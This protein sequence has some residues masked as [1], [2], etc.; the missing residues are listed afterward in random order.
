MNGFGQFFWQKS[1][2]YYKGQYEN[3]L[4]HGKGV[5]QWG[6]SRRY[7][8]DWAYG[9]RHGYGELI[10]IDPIDE[11]ENVNAQEEKKQQGIF[12]SFM[13]AVKS[14]PAKKALVTVIGGTFIQDRI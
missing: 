8:G 12:D 9:L 7:R 3:D 1:A 11:D 14:K 5:I 4:K 2:I 6:L 10:S 13:G